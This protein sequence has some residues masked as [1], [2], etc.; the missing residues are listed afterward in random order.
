MRT[1]PSPRPL[2][3]GFHPFKIQRIPRR[4]LTRLLSELFSLAALVLRSLRLTLGRARAFPFMDTLVAA[5]QHAITIV[6]L[7]GET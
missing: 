5:P 6:D 1:C 4:N 2:G 3:R 7:L